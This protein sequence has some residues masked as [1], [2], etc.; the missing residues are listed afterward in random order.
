MAKLILN[1]NFEPKLDDAEMGTVYKV[2]RG[3]A[4]IKIPGCAF[5]SLRFFITA[6]SWGCGRERCALREHQHDAGELRTPHSR[7]G[8]KNCAALSLTSRSN[9]GQTRSHNLKMVVCSS[10]TC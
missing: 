2:F 1:T 3:D 5:S 10:E 8:L 4:V 9:G 7:R 6:E